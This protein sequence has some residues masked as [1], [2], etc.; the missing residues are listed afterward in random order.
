LG[1]F[2]AFTLVA[3]SAEGQQADFE[4]RMAAMQQA[5]AR[6][7]TPAPATVRVASAD[8]GVDYTAPPAPP[9][10]R[11]ASRARIP[12]PARQPVVREHGTTRD[13]QAAQVRS[14]APAPRVASVPRTSRG[15]G[16]T[17]FSGHSII[18][19]GSPIVDDIISE[20]FVGGEVVSGEC[21]SC[22]SCGGGNYFEQNACCGRGGCPPGQPCLL[23]GLGASL[24]TALYNGEYF[25]GATA[26]R[27]RLFDTPGGAAGELSSD[28]SHGFYGG[29]N[30][31][32]P[33]CQ[34]TGGILSGQVGIRSVQTNFNGSEFTPENRD[35]LF[36][37]AGFFRRVDYGLQGG[38]VA[39]VLHEEWFTENDIVQIRGEL[40]WVFGSGRTLGVR[41]ATNTQDDI[42]DGTFNGN[43]F[44]NL[45]TSTEDTYRIFLRQER[46]GSGF[47]EIFVGT[48]ELDQTIVGLDF[49]VAVTEHVGVQA[50]FNYY[51]NNE[52][53][54]AGTTN[55]VGGNSAE[56][57]N[58][59][60]GLV[61]RPRGRAFYN[62][63]ERPLFSVADNG[64]LLI[65]RDNQ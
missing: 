46:V 3:G 64:S 22:D 7:A 8:I 38:V 31:G 42:T 34:V 47:G 35:Q 17:Q 32:L 52:G 43:S 4:R 57:F 29:F 24:G 11:V 20:S 55:V 1:Q 40:G 36:I 28:N 54:P 14:I 60:I 33:L 26:F 39:D 45:V 62:W 5:R 56:S 58:V 37:T 16:T 27:S 10:E 25:G 30:L 18:D 51:L 21:T 9:K 2:I 63:Y 23:A 53:L 12:Q 13:A 65:T 6:A 41:F 49:D 61:F 15:V 48:S 50:G 59:F 19:G 44:T